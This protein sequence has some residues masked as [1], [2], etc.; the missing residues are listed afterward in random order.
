[1][2]WREEINHKFHSKTE[3]TNNRA[4]ITP[5]NAIYTAREHLLFVTGREEG[6]GGATFRFSRDRSASLQLASPAAYLVNNRFNALDNNNYSRMIASPPTIPS[7]LPLHSF[8]KRRTPNS[9]RLFGIWLRRRFRS[10]RIYPP[11][12]LATTPL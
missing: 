5:Y 1:M 7:P 12:Y 8:E 10:G 6:R 11:R 2:Q 9:T 3:E 4:G